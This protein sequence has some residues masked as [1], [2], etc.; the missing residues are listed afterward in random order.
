MAYLKTGQEQIKQFQNKEN[1]L[2]LLAD[3]SNKVVKRDDY[4]AMFLYQNNN[5][6]FSYQK[7]T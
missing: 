2:I 7:V 6:I 1:I 4:Y 3:I 5:N